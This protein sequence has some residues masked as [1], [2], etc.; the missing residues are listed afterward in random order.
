MM[1]VVAVAAPVVAQ[2]PTVVILV[3]HA[4]KGGE[5]ADRDPELSEAGHERAR[6]L[7]HV[8]GEANIAAIYS[9]PFLRTQHTAQPLAELLGIEI[10]VTTISQTMTEDL[11]A[12]LRND[13]AGQV[14]LVVGHSNTIPPIV[15]ALGGGPYENLADDEYDD[16]FV[17]TL[18]AD[19]SAIAVRLRYGKP[20]P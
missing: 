2:S 15:N 17:V 8:L 11:V 1:V 3:R 18:A 6:T 12:T 13:H 10:T 7:A 16:M 20:T 4:E 19:G 9:T 14:V 5:P